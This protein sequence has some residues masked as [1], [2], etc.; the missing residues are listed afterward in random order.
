MQLDLLLRNVGTSLLQPVMATQKPVNY[1]WHLK[2]S[3]LGSLG[4]G[5]ETVWS[6]YTGRGVRI[7]VYDDGIDQGGAAASYGKHGTAV[8]GIIAGKLDSGAT[9]IAYHAELFDRPVIGR[10]L[11]GINAQMASQKDFD[12]VNHSW[13]WSTAFYAD[14]GK[15]AFKPFFQSFADA[16]AL[17]RDGLGTL[18]NVAAGNFKAEGID[19]NASNLSGERHAVVVAAVTSEGKATS[20]SSQGASVWIAAPSGGGTKGG[21]L[22]ADKPGA[23]GYTTGDT[24]SRFSGTSAA[25]PQV[26]GVE[27]LMLEANDQLGWR[28][29]KM[30]LALSAQASDVGKPVE[31][32]G[33]M[34]NGGGFR[35]S[36][37]VGFGILD[38][39]SAVRLA[40]TWVSSAT[41][42]NEASLTAASGN[43][44]WVRLADAGVT[45]FTIE[46]KAG[47]AIETMQLGFDG[48][49]GRVSDLVIELISPKGTVSTLL[50]GQNQAKAMWDWTFTSNAFLGETTEGTWTIRIQD[51]A[52]GQAGIVH[53]LK[54]TAFGAAETEDDTYVFTDAF[55][56]AGLAAFVLNDTAGVDV[57]NAATVTSDSV[58]D[59]RAGAISRIDG[60][61]LVMGPGTVIEI[62]FGGDGHDRILGHDE[63]AFLWG[64]RG[65][66]T[67]I[68]GAGADVIVGGLGIDMLTGGAG[69]DL[70]RFASHA[71]SGLWGRRDLILDF[72]QAEGDRIDLA[73]I[74][75]NL[76]TDADEAFLFIGSLG[77]S[78]RAG[79]LAFVAGTLAGDVNGDGLADFEIALLGVSSFGDLGLV[80]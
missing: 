48:F 34:L 28:D 6:D 32:A 38:A 27:A 29:V 42:A 61:E 74:D 65:H 51:K 77:F 16:A 4:I 44:A 80:A 10:T 7:G 11:A 31:N 54:L 46:M 37:D 22:T 25:T 23:S 33:D 41:S 67:I 57:L 26:S 30:I 12:I 58:I 70:F 50:A 75:A 64:G 36:N 35:F 20:Y 62:A 63:G 39:R 24:T 13:G 2:A 73:M 21:I 49:H 68:G 3:G 19:T 15:A 52:A 71:E 72:N 5:A 69:A 47:V 78:G 76:N 56:D 18:I 59:L 40:E 55:A 17:G 43:I 66:D 1:G 9:G 53:G 45:T 8:A 60:R 14:Q 79:E